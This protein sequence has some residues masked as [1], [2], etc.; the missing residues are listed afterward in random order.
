ML[1]RKFRVTKEDMELVIR[2]GKGPSHDFFYVKT[3]AN[4]LNNSRF[5]VIVSKKIEKT[6]VGRHLLKRRVWA[7]IDKLEKKRFKKQMDFAFFVK[8]AF[9]KKDILTIKGQVERIVL[10]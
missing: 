4:N 10:E 1:S 2:S 8:K 5:A 3:L 9:D 6:S 7:I